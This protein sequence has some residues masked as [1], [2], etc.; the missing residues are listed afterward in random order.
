MRSFHIVLLASSLSIG[1]ANA[2][3]SANEAPADGEEAA[4]SAASELRALQDNE[5]LGSMAYGDTKS[6]DYTETPLYR[7]YSFSASAN[8]SIDIWVRGTAGTDAIAWLLGADYQTLASN[9][10]AGSG[11]KDAHIAY[12]IATAGTY[13]IAFREV[14]QENSTFTVSLSKATT[15]PV[16]VFDPNTCQGTPLARAEVLHYFAPGSSASALIVKPHLYLRERRCNTATGC[17]AWT[18][19]TKGID[20]TYV[21]GGQQTKNTVKDLRV[22]A[23]VEENSYIHLDLRGTDNTN[24]YVPFYHTYVPNSS[25]GTLKASR[26]AYSVTYEGVTFPSEISV[27]LFTT[28]L[29]TKLTGSTS[30]NSSSTYKE[31]EAVFYSETLPPPY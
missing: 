30:P 31:V 16:D 10:N 28:C 21:A 29:Y 6:V 20:L 25:S 13:W 24:D 2:A 9:D 7:A 22:S 15:A 1:C 12:K 19:S 23:N 14:N 27:K 18:E 17:A 5:K 4:G 11:V 3:D 8:D 26:Q